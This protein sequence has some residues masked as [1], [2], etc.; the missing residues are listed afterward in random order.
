MSPD[1]ER[2]LREAGEILAGP[3]ASATE[4]AREV[5]LTAAAPVRRRGGGRTMAIGGA[6]LAAVAIGVGVGS[7]TLADRGEAGQPQGLGFLPADGWT[8]LQAGTPA[9]S[10]RPGVALAANVPLHPRDTADGFPYSTLRALPHH[11]VV[12]VASFMRLDD[13][14]IA[15][16]RLPLSLR[17][18]T[19]YI[20]YGGEVRPGRPL[21]QYELRAF[22]EGYAVEVHA[23]F[24]T[25]EPSGAQLAEAQ[26]QLDL[27]VVSPKTDGP[28]PRAPVRADT[29]TIAYQRFW[30]PPGNYYALRFYGTI[31]SGQPNEY[32]SVMHK[33][34]RASLSTAI[35]GATTTAG[36]GWE[37]QPSFPPG[38]GEFR[39]RWNDEL[40][41]PVQYKPPLVPNVF[42]RRGTYRV[43]VY[44]FVGPGASPVI[45]SGRW[46]EVQRL[47]AGTWSRIR[48]GKLIGFGPNLYN[49]TYYANFKLPR[50][51]TLRAFVPAKT[52]L[53]CWSSAVSKTFKS[54]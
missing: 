39:A 30:Y 3:A 32:V 9:T 20:R 34:C 50:G 18:A 15:S 37:V 53:P 10:S 43:E 47:R 36:G 41:E 19:P 27:L 21:G 33:P 48:R 42:K 4:R 2:R 17:D 22:V 12:L 14:R 8:V 28:A 11:G 23:Y 49:R 35:A 25:R 13:T 31:S 51:L 52:A 45:L 54:R 46:I 6:L 7:L 24:G 1:L 29:V 16:Q 38:A 26:R 5:A 44:S 40:S